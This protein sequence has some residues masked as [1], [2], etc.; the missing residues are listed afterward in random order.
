[1][2]KIREVGAIQLYVPPVELICLSS[3]KSTLSRLCRECGYHGN[4]SPAED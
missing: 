3:G 1:M 4:A 2:M